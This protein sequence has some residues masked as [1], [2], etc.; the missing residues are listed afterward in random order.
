MT[1]APKKGTLLRP[2]AY[3]WFRGPAK[4][5]SDL[6]VL[7]GAR[8]E[9]YEPMLEPRVGIELSRVRSPDD[10]VAFATRFGLLNQPRGILPGE[11]CPAVV[12]QSFADFERAAENLRRI[13]RIVH[14]VRA[15]TRGDGDALARVRL[16]FPPTDPDADLR[17]TTA[18]GVEIIKA[19]DFYRVFP[20]PELFATDD[21]TILLRA[22]AWAAS[23]LSNGLVSARP[24]VFDPAQLFPTS[25][26][27]PGELRIGIIG[28]SLL[29][30]CYLTIAQTL[31]S[32]PLAVCG[33][34]GRVFVVDDKRQKFCEPACAGRAR[35]RRFKNNQ[36][37]KSETAKTKKGFHEKKAR[38]R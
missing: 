14:D 15:A 19:R 28:E 8:A 2:I 36:I 16:D 7:D 32:E 21:R 20:H 34:C 9:W 25:R 35:L 17:F 27:A 26:V 11:T 31:T 24:Y 5:E 1:E 12:R 22:S 30:F 13:L 18:T 10:A 23:L 29:E 6:I 38:T 3:G 37:A 4:R 33:E